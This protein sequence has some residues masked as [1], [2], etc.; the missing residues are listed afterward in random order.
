MTTPPLRIAFCGSPEFAVASLRALC[1]DPAAFEVVAVVT[2]PDRPAGRRR[3]LSAP[4][5]KVWALAHSL[6]VH[7]FR[8]V[9]DG[10]AL[11]VL[12]ALALDVLVV[13]AYG[14]ILPRSL[15]EVARLGAINVHASLL[16]A[17]RG[18]SPIA[19]AVWHGDAESGVS[20]MRMDEGLDT[21]PV[22]SRHPLVLAAGETGESL[23][24]RLAAL[25]GE[26]LAHT[27]PQIARGLRPVAQA[28]AGVSLAPPLR[29]EDGALDWRQPAAVLERQ[30]R[31]LRPW[32]GTYT[33]LGAL[34][35]AVTAAHVE[36]G[37]TGAPPGTIVAAAKRGL[38]VACGQGALRIER[39]RPAG[40]NEMRADAWIAGRAAIK[41][42]TLTG[43]GP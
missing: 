28:D 27:L 35:L 30:V 42:A 14:R 25:G 13:A 20:I 24:A 19:R 43:H 38:V 39:L 10:A 33:F 7:Q 11:A 32:P 16:P 37:A 1:A 8:K 29:K 9:R 15:L 23:T 6:P 31:A 4:A 5:V 26:A 22:F 36:A 3:F 41:G 12:Q 40:K 18:A 17:W 34:R 2:Q 21:G